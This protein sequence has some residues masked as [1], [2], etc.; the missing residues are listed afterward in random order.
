[1]ALTLDKEQKLEAAGMIGFFNKDQAVWR[2]LAKKSYDYFKA[3]LPDDSP[4]RPDDVAKVLHPIIEVNEDLRDYLN[5]YKLK[6]KY[7]IS[8]FTDLVIDRTWDD[9]RK[10]E[11]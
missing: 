8:D 7:W 3:N 11:G 9:I 6:Q 2:E 4:V 10:G 5:K 1:M